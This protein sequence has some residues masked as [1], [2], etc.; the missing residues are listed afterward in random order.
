MAL[1]NNLNE[2]KEKKNSTLNGFTFLCD[3]GNAAAADDDC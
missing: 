1:I 3:G 2:R